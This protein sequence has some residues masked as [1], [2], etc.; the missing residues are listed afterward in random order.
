MSGKRRSRRVAIRKKTR[1][2]AKKHTNRNESDIRYNEEHTG[3]LTRLLLEWTES[4][5]RR[6]YADKMCQMRIIMLRISN[7]TF[8]FE[9]I[10]FNLFAHRISVRAHMRAGD[11]G[12]LFCS[13]PQHGS[14]VATSRLRSCSCVWESEN[15]DYIQP[16]RRMCSRDCSTICCLLEIRWFERS[17]IRFHA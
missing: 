4:I 16:H 11:G 15:R 3:P 1:N 6:S 12:P 2:G 17:D 7:F 8:E 14:S 13:A 5:G 10:I 9:M